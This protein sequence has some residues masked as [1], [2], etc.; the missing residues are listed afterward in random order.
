MNKLFEAITLKELGAERQRV[1]QQQE[2]YDQEPDNPAA[3][4][5]KRWVPVPVKKRR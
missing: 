2:R 4:E 3:M 5:A 1:R